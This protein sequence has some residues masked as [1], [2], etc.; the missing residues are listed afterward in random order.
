[1]SWTGESDL[2]SPPA[3]RFTPDSAYDGGSDFSEKGDHM[4]GIL[5]GPRTYFD[6][7]CVSLTEF[8]DDAGSPIEKIFQEGTSLVYIPLYLTCKF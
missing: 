5:S 7:P 4:Q 1:M 3:K 6:I 8:L 2:R